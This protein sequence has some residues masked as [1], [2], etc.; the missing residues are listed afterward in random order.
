M[1]TF[2]KNLLSG[3]NEAAPDENFFISAG[4]QF[5][6]DLVAKSSSGR[7]EGTFDGSIIECKKLIV[8][9][10]AN[11]KG[12]IFAHEIVVQGYCEG[13]IYTSGSIRVL[14]GAVVLGDIYASSLV[15]DRKATFRG[16]LRKLKPEDYAEMT[17]REKERIIQMRK[18]N[19]FSI[20]SV[21]ARMDA[22]KVRA[23]MV[24]NGDPVIV[25]PESEKIS[26]VKTLTM[27][28]AIAIDM[29]TSKKSSPEAPVIPS[30]QLNKGNDKTDAPKTS[31]KPQPAAKKEE[32]KRWF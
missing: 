25:Q 13:N 28:E 22:E 31:Q 4:L 32:F 15:V 7:I 21:Q 27:E 12:N 20:H 11:I 5:F 23:K 3:R 6:G 1:S 2:F 17:G 18:S 8:G 16:N 9:M 24:A 19:V 10:N 30:K 29:E 26:L 14:E